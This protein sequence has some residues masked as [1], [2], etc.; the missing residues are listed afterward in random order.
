MR[1]L[2][3]IFLALSS[4]S[5]SLY[6]FDPVLTEQLATFLGKL[7]ADILIL[8][9]PE[10]Y[11]QKIDERIEDYIRQGADPNTRFDEGVSAIVLKRNLYIERRKI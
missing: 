4:L 1:N 6:A 2:S 7:P 10:S 5:L 11:L 8:D 3:F 9:Y